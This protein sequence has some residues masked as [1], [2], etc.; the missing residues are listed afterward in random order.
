MTGWDW[1]LMAVVALAIAAGVFL[2]WLN[3]LKDALRDPKDR[4][5]I[6]DD[7]DFYT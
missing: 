6:R 3:P 5:R 7:E 4:Q 1:A 2:T